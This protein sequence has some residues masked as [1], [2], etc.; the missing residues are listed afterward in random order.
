MHLIV[1]FAAPLSA[2]GQ[3]ALA[4]TPLPQLQ[5]CLQQMRRGAT[6]AGDE[7]S[8]TAP[9]ELVLAQALAWVGEDG[10]WPWAARQL[11]ALGHAP[12]SAAWGL[13]TP[14]HWHLGTEQVSLGDPATLMLDE[15]SS[16]ALLGDVAPLFTSEGFDVLWVAP[17]MWFIAHPSLAS[18]PCA[19][20]DRVIG[21]NVDRWLPPAKEARLMRRLQNEV[22]MLLHTH[23]LNA[24]REARGLLPVNSVWLSGCGVRQP[25]AGTAPRVDTRLRGP[26]LAGDWA[27]W[28]KAWT[29]ID[30]ELPAL[31]IERL[32]LCGERGAV[33]FDAVPRT[34]WSRITS[35]WRQPAP[36]SMLAAL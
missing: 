21:R 3:Q 17:L 27:A 10:R 19:S 1:P 33:S 8:F 5:R 11:A 12:G 31:P 2:Q 32:T 24:E 36:A 35:T 14:T 23:P 13:L 7:L 16:R 4:G 30:D 6:L 20:L 9:H 29:V 18:V 26:A 34:L 28:S 22:Q 25:E 15:S